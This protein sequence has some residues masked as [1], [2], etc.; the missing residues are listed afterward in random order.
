MNEMIFK[1]ADEI[2][3]IFNRTS[4]DHDE[5]SEELFRKVLGLVFYV[6][7]NEVIQPINRKEEL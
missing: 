2:N 5:A 6:R 3:E 7:F 4:V 1:L